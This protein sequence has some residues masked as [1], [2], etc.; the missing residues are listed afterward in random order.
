MDLT[1]VVR[2]S[3][4]Q[5]WIIIIAIITMGIRVA[6]EIVRIIIVLIIIIIMGDNWI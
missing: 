5:V 1:K 2:I 3:I 6:M 4:I